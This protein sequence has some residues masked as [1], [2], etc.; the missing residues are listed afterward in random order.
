[1]KRIITLALCLVL[2]FTITVPASAAG[3]IHLSISASSGSAYRGDT[4]TFYISASGGGS[5]KTFGMALSYDTSVFELVSSNASVSGAMMASFGGG[6]L[7]V[8]YEA[9][10]VPSG[11]VASFTLRVKSGASFGTHSVSGRVNSEGAQISG[12]GT[13]V[14]VKC[15]HQYGDWQKYTADYHQK[16]CSICNGTQEE[17][18]AWND[19]TV[20]SE[21]SCKVEGNKT[22][23]CTVCGEVK[24]EVL[25]KTDD[26]NYG[27]PQRVD[28][29]NHQS[30][31][32]ICDG[33]LTEGHTWNEGEVT[34][35][36][37]CKETGLKRY[38]CT[39][40][41]ATYEEVIPLSEEHKYSAWSN[42]SETSHYHKCSVCDKEET[43]DHT[44]NSGSVTKKPNCI[45]TGTCLYTCT[46][47][48]ATKTDDM[49]ITGKHTY[50]HGC[51]KDCNVCG[52]TRSTSHAYEKSWSKNAKE[53]WHVCKNCGNKADTAKHVPGEEATEFNPQLCT[54]C[55]YMLKPELAHEH[56]FGE[57]FTTD[58]IAHWYKCVGCEEQKE[59]AEHLFDNACDG[60]CEICEYTRET[61]HDISEAW[62][63]DE[64]THYQKCMIC[65]QEE[66]HIRHTAGPEATEF[67][68]QTCEIC[69]FELMPAL[70][71]SFAQA[72]S[73]DELTHY[74]GCACGERADA[75]DH[76]WDEG[77]RNSEG[78]TYTCTV[79]Q[80]QRFEPLDL[81]W[82]LYTAIGIVVAGAVV[83][84]V[85]I[86][87]KKK[88]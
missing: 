57:E 83:A 51:D 81:S 46:G 61:T 4:V 75:A 23:T 50:D 41:G 40:C 72:W 12:S 9:E 47:C 2:L 34:K 39:A 82:L 68:P 18:H 20:T 14:T 58:E 13:S 59:Y 31:C 37:T 15:S 45:E 87:K 67:D 64:E 74:H 32:S 42:V 7:A 27:T 66:E 30:T 53:H 10:G 3:S 17:G 29:T 85:I 60:L 79:C 16:T 63:T 33:I 77:V 62:Y 56:N 11:T 73:S 52:A 6:T 1:M 55:D 84:V 28:G 88:K 65:G 78:T 38:T 43:L 76:L 71:H 8:L 35:K 44:W 22:Y 48:G 36:E 25:S 24:N 21:P 69:G 49:P 5:C 26:H 70:G 86:A 19:G 80:Y 54:V